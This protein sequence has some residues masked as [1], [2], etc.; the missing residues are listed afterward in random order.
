MLESYIQNNK[1]AIKEPEKL[2]DE[3]KTK[4]Y[5]VAMKLS[6]NKGEYSPTK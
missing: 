6:Q 3:A 5:N 1:P 4:F 2:K